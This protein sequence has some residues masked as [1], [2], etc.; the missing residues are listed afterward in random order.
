MKKDI[1]NGQMAILKEREIVFKEFGSGIFLNPIQ[2]E[3]SEYQNN[4]N[5]QIHRAAM[6]N[7]LH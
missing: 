6:I 1:L 5:N 3:Q 4:Q 7:K 2:S